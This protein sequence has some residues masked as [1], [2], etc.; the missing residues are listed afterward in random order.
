MTVCSERLAPARELRRRH[1]RVVER[2]APARH[3]HKIG[4]REI[5]QQR[6]ERG[7]IGRCDHRIEEAQLRPSRDPLL[8][9]LEP[10]QRTG[11][12]RRVGNPVIIEQ[13]HPAQSEGLVSLATARAHVDHL[14]TRR[15][16][17]LQRCSAACVV[18]HDDAWLERVDGVDDLGV[19]ERRRGRD[20]G[21]GKAASGR[22]G[23]VAVQQKMHLD[24]RPSRR[25]C[26]GKAPCAGELAHARGAAHRH[27]QHSRRRVLSLDGHAGRTHP[28]IHG[29]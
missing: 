13:P 16:C 26:F 17:R 2:A 29:L 6:I 20:Q 1:R 11:D 7:L 24:L 28:G 25:H 14:G 23:R 18:E 19:A 12:R 4:C 21:G 8:Q 10:A 22:V 3:D 5:G 27:E 9:A 15:P